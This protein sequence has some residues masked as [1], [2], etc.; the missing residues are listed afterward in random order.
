MA[1]RQELCHKRCHGILKATVE[2][3][4]KLTVNSEVSSVAV[5]RDELDTSWSHYVNAFNLHEDSLIGKDDITIGTINTEYIAMHN[6]YLCTKLHLRKLLSAK[7]TVSSLHSTLLDGTNGANDEAVKTIK[8]PPIKI[9]PFSGDLKDWT[10]FKATCRSILTEKISDVQRLQYLKEALSGEPRELVAHILPADGAYDRAMQ[11]LVNRFENT[12]AIV[13]MHLKRLY[14][15]PR[16]ES[17]TETIGTLRK[18]INTINGLKA[19][20]TGIDIETNTWDSILIYN[21]SRCLQ[22]ISLKA[23]E[24]RLEGKRTIPSLQTY[25]DFLETRITILENTASF[26][27]ATPCL[28]T[29]PFDFS[30][31]DP[32]HE[33]VRSFYTLKA[34][35]KCLIC[36]GNHLSN[37]CDSLSSMSVR[38]RREAVKNSG[39]CFNCL[40]SHL[41]ANCPFEPACKKCDQ[42]HHTMLHE[43]QATVMLNQTDELSKDE[44]LECIASNRMSEFAAAQFYHI[45]SNAITILPTALVPVRWNGQSIILRALVDQG[46]TTNLITNQACR[47]LQ[48]NQIRTNAPMTGIGNSPIGTALAKTTLSFGSIYD[49]S[50][51]HDISSMVVQS[52][53]STH[54]IESYNANKWQHLTHLPMANPQFFEHNR[55]DLL[56]GASAY[57]EIILDGITKGKTDEPIAQQTKLGWIVSGTACVDENCGSAGRAIQEQPPDDSNTESW[58]HQKRPCQM[59]SVER[60]EQVPPDKQAAKPNLATDHKCYSQR[61]L[62]TMSPS[63]EY[64]RQS[65]ITARTV[66]DIAAKI[67]H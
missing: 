47:K 28:K 44:S 25:L 5:F 64:P 46:S 41:V 55:I 20:L 11:L 56:L 35:F 45:T 34:D 63:S 30:I 65:I 9:T 26:S 3:A 48:L 2:Q 23:W 58:L 22:P 16:D 21:T 4:E 37:R 6:T 38:K 67:S 24:E 49:T 32:M 40:Q 62:A 61:S 42:N 59:K 17:E 8:M 1:T 51:K 54:A 27:I 60:T 66:F 33:K 39:V 36:N 29:E 31:R 7:S 19:A 14:T 18:I 15:I 57:A 53:A 43:E 10:E 13:N 50:Y 52:I 12:R